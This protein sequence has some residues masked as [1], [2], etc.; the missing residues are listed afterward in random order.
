MK[1]K[2]KKL[3]VSFLAAA[4]AFAG[5]PVTALAGGSSL[6]IGFVRE[7]NNN[8][9]KEETENTQTWSGSIE[10]PGNTAETNAGEPEENAGGQEPQAA[11]P[12]TEPGAGEPEE[13]AGG[14]EPQAAPQQTEPT[15]EAPVQGDVEE[16]PDGE[17]TGDEA[18]IEMESEL[19][20]ETEPEVMISEYE[21]EFHFENEEVVITIKAKEEAQLPLGTEMIVRKL[22][23][24]S[25]EYLEAKIA[26]DKQ[27]GADPSLTEYSFYNMKLM[28]PEGE[29]LTPEEGLVTIQM[30]FK[31]I[32]INGEDSGQNV[33]N[34]KDTEQGKVA[35]NVTAPEA[36]MAEGEN[37]SSIDFEV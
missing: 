19:E 26:A 3:S 4:L 36:E 21:T 23:K 30:E 1:R 17:L 16:V 11:P 27:A 8:E 24:D 35:E 5:L 37:L 25:E 12:Q 15:T 13:S 2:W 32:K 9:N 33:Y 29:E 34:I 28:S 7:G 22:E 10:K 20:T 31:N 18:Q 14:Q 6:T